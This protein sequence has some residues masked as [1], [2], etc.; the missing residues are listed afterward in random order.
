[1]KIFG[2]YS[3][4][5]PLHTNVIQWIYLRITW[6]SLLVTYTNCYFWYSFKVTCTCT[7]EMYRLFKA[8]FLSSLL[9][10]ILMEMCLDIINQ[11]FWLCTLYHRTRY[12]CQVKTAFNLGKCFFAI[13]FLLSNETSFQE[14]LVPH[15]CNAM[16]WKYDFILCM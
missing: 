1:M 8:I 14:Q 7:C 2:L 11:S 6:F 15:V 13:L 10:F 5:A 3:K 16:F 4:R 12:K 9:F